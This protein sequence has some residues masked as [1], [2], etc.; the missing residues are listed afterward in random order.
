VSFTAS[1]DKALWHTEPKVMFKGE[2]ESKLVT[3]QGLN[4]DSINACSRIRNYTGDHSIATNSVDF[5]YFWSL[6]LCFPD[7]F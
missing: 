5:T 6:F 7:A 1:Q 3:Q 2:E 4:R